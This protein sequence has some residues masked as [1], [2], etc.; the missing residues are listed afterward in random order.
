MHKKQ[1]IVPQKTKRNHNSKRNA[2]GSDIPK[3]C[4]R[5]SK[6][7]LGLQDSQPREFDLQNRPN[8][9]P[10]PVLNRLSSSVTRSTSDFPTPHLASSCDIAT[11]P[12]SLTTPSGLHALS[13]IF[14]LSKE[15]FAK[16]LFELHG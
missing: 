8:P 11:K 2:D 6:N 16:Y 14:E 12:Y 5:R 7:A 13:G 1:D 9:R 10:Q 4:G 3:S 15:S